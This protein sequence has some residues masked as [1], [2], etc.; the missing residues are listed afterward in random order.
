MADKKLTELSAAT[1]VSQTDQLY[2]VSSGNGMYRMNVKT[3]H[4][5][6][7]DTT[8]SSN[9][10]LGASQ[11]MTSPGTINNT[12]AIT[13]ITAGA[14]SGDCTISQGTNGQVKIIVMKSTAGGIYTINSGLGANAVVVFEKAGHAAS[15][16][17]LSNA[18]FV[19]GGTASITLP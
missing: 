7:S 13:T 16:V 5:T 6:I 14:D 15:F 19:T 3:L 18:W 11:N 9:I 2:V 17:Y 4:S 10:R 1:S 8:L 12:T